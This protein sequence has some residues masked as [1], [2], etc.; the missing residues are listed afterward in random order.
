MLALWG[1]YLAL[2]LIYMKD[3]AMLDWTP[4]IS[5]YMKCHYI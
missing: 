5:L 1:V 3:V 2:Q 4:K